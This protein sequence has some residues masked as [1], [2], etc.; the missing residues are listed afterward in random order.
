MTLALI[1]IDAYFPLAL[2]L[3]ARANS[4]TGW[5]PSSRRKPTGEARC[6]T[7]WAK[8][9]AWVILRILSRSACGLASMP[10]SL[11]EAMLFS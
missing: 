6:G 5:R 8:A 4:S 3:K 2:G 10:I 1:P 11:T 7:T 9:D